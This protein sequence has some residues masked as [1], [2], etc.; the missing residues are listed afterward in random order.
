[1]KAAAEGT[2]VGNSSTY[3][4]KSRGTVQI[5]SEGRLREHDQDTTANTCWMTSALWAR[6]SL[7]GRI[8]DSSFM[9][10]DSPPAA[11][12]LSH[13]GREDGERGM[14]AV[15][16]PLQ[17]AEW[18]IN[19]HWLTCMLLQKRKREWTKGACEL[20]C[21]ISLNSNYPEHSGVQVIRFLELLHT[22]SQD[23]ALWLDLLPTET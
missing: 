4:R 9:Q 6:W 2:E 13:R 14:S 8:L 16:H 23:E 7:L 3:T 19:P 1:M 17:D 5:Y 22:D 10:K 11:Q 20:N 15:Q 12:A 21:S 18:N